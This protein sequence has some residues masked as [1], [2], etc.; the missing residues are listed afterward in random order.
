MTA[1]TATAS[2]VDHPSEKRLIRAQAISG[3]VFGVFLV[4]HL[5]NFAAGLFG[6]AEYDAWMRASRGYYQ[7]P[8]VEIVGVLG[9]ALVHTATALIR[10]LRRRRRARRQTTVNWRVRLHRFSGYYMMVAFVGHVVATRGPGL[11]DKPASYAFVNFS[12]TY[13]GWFFVPYYVGLAAAGFYHLA[14][15]TMAALRVIGL[16][17]PKVATASRSWVFWLAIGLSTGLSALGVAALSGAIYPPD[18]SE[19]ASW[20]EFAS[21]YVPEAL[22]PW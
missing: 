11:L 5:L 2:A 6:Q 22:Q 8:V 16:R 17:L 4:L 7:F 1:A 21:K 18:Q 3:L 15:G 13:A 10:I 12:L 20:K 14:H 19:H 9:A